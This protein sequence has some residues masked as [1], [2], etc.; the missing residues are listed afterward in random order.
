MSTTRKFL[1]S[2]ANIWAFDQNDVLLFTGKTLLDSSIEVSLSSQEIR[3]GIGNARQ[4]IFYHSAAMNVTISEAQFNL[5]YLASTV[6]SAIATGNSVYTEEN[7]TLDGSF[8]GSVTGTPLVLPSSGA[9]YGWVTHVD[10]TI[11]RVTFT[12]QAFVTA[13]T[14][15]EN[16]VVC[17]RY[18]ATDAASRS[19]TI[20]S[21]FIPKIVRLVMEAQLNSSDDAA[22]K[23]GVVQIVIPKL[24]LSGAF[25]I[26]MKADGVSNT[27]LTGMALED[28]DLTTASCTNVGQ[29]AKIIEVLDSANWYD[30]VIGLSIAGGD[31]SLAHPNTTRRLVV[32]AIKNDGSA[33]FITPYDGSVDFTSGTAGTATINIDSGIISTVAAGTTLLKATIHDKNTIEGSC[34][35][36]VTS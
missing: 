8:G 23:I 19:L 32:Y 20:N 17:V 3:G 24:Q 30:D 6:G 22:N 1:T 10:G 11:E 21:N 34:T 28:R 31:F 13:T 16:D 18:Y 25:S 29:Y 27:P 2:V 15:A 9:L 7:V 5:G 26:S 35:L 36:T 33:P 4:F 12:G 14:G